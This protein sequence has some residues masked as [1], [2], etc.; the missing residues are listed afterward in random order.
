MSFTVAQTLVRSRS[1]YMDI[2][3]FQVE[4]VLFRIPTGYLKQHSAIFNDMFSL[5]PQPGAG[6]GEG[7]GEEGQ[8]DKTPIR[9]DD[10]SKDDFERFLEV[11]LTVNTQLEPNQTFGTSRW[12]SVLKLANLW[13]FAYLRRTAIAKLSSSSNGALLPVFSPTEHIYYGRLHKVEQWV[14]QGYAVLVE[15]NEKINEAE[16]TCLGW[17]AVLK[18]CHLREEVIGLLK[19]LG[20]PAHRRSK[21]YLVTMLTVNTAV[22]RTFS[23]EL[24]DIRAAA[25][26]LSVPPPVRGSLSEVRQTAPATFNWDMK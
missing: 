11:I 2:S 19:S 26:A 12:L 15:R 7:E 10:V 3:I 24:H 22:R 23:A 20:A 9:L 25:A 6:E 4:N 1:F 17:G 14:E 8:S 18:L 16:A 13:G 5:K 21:E